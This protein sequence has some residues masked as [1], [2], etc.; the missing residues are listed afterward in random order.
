MY[1]IEGNMKE[2]KFTN[3]VEAEL[4]SPEIIGHGFQ[5]TAYHNITQTINGESVWTMRKYVTFINRNREFY[6]EMMEEEINCLDISVEK[7]RKGNT[8][9]MRKVLRENRDDVIG[10]PIQPQ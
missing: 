10:S 4:D 2:F 6:D 8:P 9:C 1:E 7:N 5:E 3:K